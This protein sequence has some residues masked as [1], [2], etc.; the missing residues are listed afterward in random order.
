MPKP[1]TR[2]TE[3]HR[4]VLTQL[5]SLLGRSIESKSPVSLGENTLVHLIV[6][7]DKVP[8]PPRIHPKRYMHVSA[9]VKGACPRSLSLERRFNKFQSTTVTGAMRIV[10]EIGRKVEQHVRSQ[11]VASVPARQIYGQWKCPCG[12]R[13]REGM[14]LDDN[15][16]KR[17]GLPASQ[18]V[19][20]DLEDDN[21]Y[22]TG[23]PDLVLILDGAIYPA[24]IKSLGN[25]KS[26]NDRN[27]GFNTIYKPFV[28]HVLQVSCYHKMLVPLSKRLGLPLGK[29]CII[30][31]ASKDFDGFR[32]PY[33]YKEFHINPFDFKEDVQ[34][35]F[36]EAREAYNGI[37]G[38]LPPRLHACSSAG[39]KCALRCPNV[40]ECFAL[41]SGPPKL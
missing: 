7:Q 35:M 17:C 21:Y 4:P 22:V 14:A 27:E 40:H 2:P 28:D 1:V 11:L 38:I 24:E 33:P 16:C 37:Q 29:T 36:N 39:T 32:A 25:S 5:A 10:W 19:E 20:L 9:L 34:R 30:L 18:Y 31:Y 13:T 3:A 23:H 41:P 8:E 6:K 26:A 12:S 15:A